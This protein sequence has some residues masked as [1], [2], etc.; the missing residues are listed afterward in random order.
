MMTRAA[1]KHPFIT[2]H[3]GSEEDTILEEPEITHSR[4]GSIIGKNLA[5][6]VVGELKKT[7]L[8]SK[9]SKVSVSSP[10]HSQQ[11]LVYF[12]FAKSVPIF[13]FLRRVL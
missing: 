2:A 3:C 5:E 10:W 8:E 4:K 6:S 1:L 12:I 11:A 9:N 13:S 7:M